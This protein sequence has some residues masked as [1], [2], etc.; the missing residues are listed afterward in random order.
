ME[1]LLK[2]SV[3]FTEKHGK[4]PS[5]V[6]LSALGFSQ[7]KVRRLYGSYENLKDDIIKNTDAVL[8]LSRSKFNTVIKNKKTYFITTAITNSK[9]DKKF[10]KSINTFCAV[11]NAQLLILPSFYNPAG[12]TKE[13]ILDKELAGYTII[14]SEKKINSNVFLLGIKNTASKIDPIT[15]LPRVGQRNGT[16]IAASPKQRLKYVPT[17][18]NTLPHALMST[19]AITLPPYIKGDSF[20]K[21]N[22]YIANVDHVMG[23]IVLELDVND[24]FHFRQVQ[25]APDGSFNDLGWEYS[26]TKFKKV[27]PAAL[28]LGDWHSGQTCPIA[29][30]ALVKLTKSL[31]IEKW[32]IHDLFDGSSI[33]HHNEHRIVTQA[34]LAKANKLNLSNEIDGVCSDLDEMRKLVKEVVIVKSN[35]DEHLDRYLEEARFT[36]DPVNFS[37]GSR[38]ASAMVEQRVSPLQHEVTNRIGSKGITWLKRDE[39][40]SIGGIQLGSHGDKGAN[41]A[42]GSIT[43]LE[44]AYGDVVF[45]H[46]HTPQILRKAFCVGTTSV[47]ELGYNIG[48]SSWVQTS[49]IVYSNGQ[50]QLVNIINGKITTRL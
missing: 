30:A 20:T 18:P 35:H 32:I 44:A 24:T 45:G 4:Y 2:V 46:S 37:L 22:D 48:P 38:L 36:R 7:D 1:E 28:V 41:G 47:L 5:R 21:Q 10:L 29:K 14:P 25:A 27:K 42:R 8:D 6:D 3:A 19:G 11:S 12:G 13:L 33:S 34:K 31:G 9:V 43:S 26:G 16:F 49:C 39:D 23:G 17:G 50:R 15:G 40:Y